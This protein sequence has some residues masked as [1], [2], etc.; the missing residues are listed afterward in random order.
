MART[1]TQNLSFSGSLNL[2]QTLAGKACELSSTVDASRLMT[3]RAASTREPLSNLCA[4]R[5]ERVSKAMRQTTATR[6][7][8]KTTARRMMTRKTTTRKKR[9]SSEGRIAQKANVKTASPA[10]DSADMS[11]RP[12]RT[13]RFRP[14]DSNGGRS[15][16]VKMHRQRM[17]EAIGASLGGSS[18]CRPSPHWSRNCIM[19]TKAQLL[20]RHRGLPHLRLLAQLQPLRR[21]RL[22]PASSRRHDPR[23]SIHCQ[24]LCT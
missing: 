5:S 14:L 17:E 9:S 22:G 3:R 21:P 24:G 6:R 1:S 4:T 18:S 11:P 7:M 23:H 16:H 19:L 13:R 20:P 15:T 8:T 2:T 10:C 12:R